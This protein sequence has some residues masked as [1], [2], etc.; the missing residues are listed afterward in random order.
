M[1][2]MRGITFLIAAPLMTNGVRT[3]VKHS[4][5]LWH[6]CFSPHLCLSDGSYDRSVIC[7]AH[8]ALRVQ[9]QIVGFSSLNVDRY[10][11]LPNIE[12]RLDVKFM[13]RRVREEEVGP[14]CRIHRLSILW[15]VLPP[16][17]RWLSF[18]LFFAN[19]STNC[20]N[21]EFQKMLTFFLKPVSYLPLPSFA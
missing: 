5:P 15:N 2:V 7:S 11:L 1:L 17:G 16:F 13:L 14:A 18:G 4:R 3:K 21:N 10:L 12:G 20:V 19:R 9:D 6:R 8:S